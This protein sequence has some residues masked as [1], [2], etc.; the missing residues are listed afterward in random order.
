M[1]FFI[2]YTYNIWQAISVIE[3]IPPK[4]FYFIELCLQVILL[5]TPA[6]TDRVLRFQAVGIL[7]QTQ[8]RCNTTT[9]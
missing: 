2:H 5:K 9:L 4:V 8:K 7:S 1:H 6:L 3:L